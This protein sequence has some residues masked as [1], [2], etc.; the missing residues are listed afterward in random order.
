MSQR[1]F[2]SRSDRRDEQHGV[3]R[4]GWLSPIKECVIRRG[5]NDIIDDNFKK[6]SMS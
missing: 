2:A 3:G 1:T 4:N 5:E 6:S